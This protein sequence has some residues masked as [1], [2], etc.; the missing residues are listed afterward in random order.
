MDKALFASYGGVEFRKDRLV[1]DLK[2]VVTDTDDLLKEVI[3]STGEEFVAARGKIEVQLRDARAR[4]DATRSALVQQVSHAAEATQDYARENPWKA[5]GIP[6]VVAV[7]AFLV[8]S[9]R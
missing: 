3:N 2:G 5:Y 9:R 8:L 4:L 6:A 7:L 1:R